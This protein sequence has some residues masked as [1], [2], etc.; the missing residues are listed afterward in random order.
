MKWL[1]SEHVLSVYV[2]VSEQSFF[3][4]LLLLFCFFLGFFFCFFPKPLAKLTNFLQKRLNVIL[5]NLFSK[6]V[7]FVCFDNNIDFSII[8]AVGLPNYDTQWPRSIVTKKVPLLQEANNQ[9][10]DKKTNALPMSS[11]GKQKRKQHKCNER[12]I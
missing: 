3:L 7:M 9:F 6:E 2:Y 8:S 11:A 10:F 1:N 4:L 5:L 12:I